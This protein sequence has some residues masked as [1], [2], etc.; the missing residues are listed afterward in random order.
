MC[1]NPLT[2]FKYG[3]EFLL[4]VLRPHRADSSHRCALRAWFR[5]RSDF[6][7][8]RNVITL[9]VEDGGANGLRVQSQR[10]QTVHGAFLP[11]S[12]PP[13]SRSLPGGEVADATADGKINSLVDRFTF[14]NLGKSYPHAA[15]W[16]HDS[17]YLCRAPRTT[18]SSSAPPCRSL[19]MRDHPSD[20]KGVDIKIARPDG[21]VGLWTMLGRQREQQYQQ[22][23]QQHQSDQQDR[24]CILSC[25]PLKGF[26]RADI[27]LCDKGYKMGIL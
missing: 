18:E 5:F 16:P 19:V 25:L 15:V 22:H 24:F 9:H 12:S 8:F 23:Q 20:K 17:K 10:E 6:S 11:S 13:A 7:V 27:A 2:F 3:R 14:K 21:G 1:F 26:E 4:T